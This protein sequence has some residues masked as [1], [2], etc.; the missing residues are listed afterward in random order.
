MTQSSSPANG[1]STRVLLLVEDNPGD[2]NL[3]RELLEQPG[4]HTYQIVHV[5]R[6]GDAL[7]RLTSVAVDVILLDL[8]LPDGSGIETLRSVREVAGEVPIVVL[9]G[10]DDEQL[11]L[12]CIDCGAQDYL[13]KSEIRDVTLRRAIGYAITRLREAQVH[14]LQ[15]MLSRYHALASEGAGTMV[16][17]VLAGTGAVKERYPNIFLQ[18]VREYIGLLAVYLDQLVVKKEKPKDLME[19]IVTNIGNAGGGPRDLL[20]VHLQA[21]DE[22]VRGK[23]FKRSRA[24]AIESRLLALEMMGLLVDHYR[25]GNRR[26]IPARK[27]S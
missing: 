19:H 1:V 20:D 17:A 8:R 21:L 7:E 4:D 10:T 6:L 15:Q 25:V 11:A 9:T 18:M 12:E 13:N 27:Q 24:S 26:W 2:A 5:E 22:F 23:D 3:V 14:E 16:T